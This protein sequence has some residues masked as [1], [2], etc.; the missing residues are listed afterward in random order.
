MPFDTYNLL[1]LANKLSVLGGATLEEQIMFLQ[2]QIKKPFT[3]NDSNYFKEIKD[4]VSDK[5][6][7]D[8]ICS[9]FI[10]QILDVYPNLTI[11]LSDYEKHLTGFFSNVYKFFIRDARKMMYLF[12][13]EYV[14]NNKNR[15]GLTDPY[16]TSAVVN[17]PKEQYGK[18]EFYLLVI[19]LPRIID[20]IFSDG[21]KL[22][23]F[24]EY[25]SRSDDAPVYLDY[26]RE[27]MLEGYIVDN[28]VVYDMYR[29]FK[30]SDLYRSEINKLE[31]DIYRSLIIP[32]ME[33]NGLMGVRIPEVEDIPEEPTDEEDDTD[34]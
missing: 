22:K 12:I 28:G 2:D 7:L 5:D 23:K 21:V 29:M 8:E 33:A 20:D 19:K 25:I 27:R 4:Q 16:N 1:Q 34:E 18:K 30:A 24:I 15:K 14:F 13:R 6:T 9:S 26:I 10:T 11:D 17:Y 31:T 3:S 32:Y